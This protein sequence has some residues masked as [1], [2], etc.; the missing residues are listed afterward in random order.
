MAPNRSVLARKTANALLEQVSAGKS[1]TSRSQDPPGG[2]VGDAQNGGREHKRRVAGCRI[3][4]EE[5]CLIA[6]VISQAPKC[7]EPEEHTR[8]C[9]KDRQTQ[10]IPSCN[11]RPFMGDNGRELRGREVTRKSL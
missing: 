4:G 2:P 3:V 7:R 10:R 11:V 6:D 8:Q 9:A 1:H 5:F